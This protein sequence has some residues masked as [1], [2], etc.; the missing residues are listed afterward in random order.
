[1]YMYTGTLEFIS[2]TFWCILAFQSV[3]FFTYIC[4]KSYIWLG[5]FELVCKILHMKLPSKS[6]CKIFQYKI[7]LWNRKNLLEF[8]VAQWSRSK[9]SA[10]GGLK[11]NT[12]IKKIDFKMISQK[13]YIWL[14]PKKQHWCTC[15]W[16]M[17][18]PTQI[19]KNIF[20]K[21]NGFPQAEQVRRFSGVLL[22]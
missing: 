15:T 12:S 22:E 9:F 17:E 11:Y 10:C 21:I 4:R 20:V 7:C 1:M 19:Q 18:L 13:S 3:V 5:N 8:C 6:I 14:K 2:N 16:N